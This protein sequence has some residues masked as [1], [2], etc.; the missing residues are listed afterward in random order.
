MNQA[1]LNT[2]TRIYLVKINT[3]AVRG[4][5]I[6]SDANELIKI[7]K[8]G[9][10]KTRGIEYLK[11]FDTSKDKFVRISKSDFLNFNS[12]DTELIEYCKNIAYFK[13]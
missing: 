12:F 8:Q 5:F 3:L 2:D 10:N 1:T 9:D 4:K 6:F 7:L 11:T 13:K